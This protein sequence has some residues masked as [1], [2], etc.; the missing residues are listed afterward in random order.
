MRKALLHPIVK[1]LLSTVFL[2]GSL[3]LIKSFI[4]KPLFTRLIANEAGIKMV[5]ALVSV[6]L[7]IGIYYLLQRFYL[8]GE[9]QEFKRASFLPQGLGGL[10][11]GLGVISLVIFCLYLLG[12]YHILGQNAWIVFLPDAT[13]ILGAALLEE[14]IFRGFIFRQLEKWQGTM[15]ALVVS[16]LVFQLP[17]FMNPHESLLPALL[18]VLFGAVHA[19][20]YAYTRQ[21]WL[22]VA[23]HFGWNLAQPFFGTTLSGI[24]S[25]QPFFLAEMDGPTLLTGSAFG[26]E[27]S[28]LSFL[29]LVILGWLYYR[30]VRSKGFWV[31][32]VKG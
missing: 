25:F 7:L 8:K 6:G 14:L 19:L 21:L 20:M 5:T 29:M 17:H 28:L 13:V 1:I 27:D 32:R 31:N 10:A 3:G 30:G 18:G 24:D 26:V 23:F 2:I 9:R 16:S 11:L 15:L 22:P 12:F 4:T